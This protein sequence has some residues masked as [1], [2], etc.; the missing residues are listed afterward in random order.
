M[1][2]S[3]SREK[4]GRKKSGKG[5]SSGGNDY[6]TRDNRM[7][8][9]RSQVKCFNCGGYGH[10][11]AECRKPRKV[12]QQK[13]EVNLTWL[14]DSEPALLMVMCENNADELVTF[15]E[16]NSSIGV[17]ENEEN[18]WY[19]NNGAS[20]HM[21]DRREKFEKLDR[22]KK[23]EVK[24]GDGSVEQGIQVLRSDRGGE[25]CSNEFKNFCEDNGILR[26]Y[27][28]PYTPQQNGV[29][30]R[31]NR[32]VVAMARSLLKE[33]KVPLQFWGEAVRYAVHILN[34]LPTRSKSIVTPHEA[35]YGKKPSVEHLKIFGC[36]TYMK[37][38]AVQTTKLDDRSKLVSGC[39]FNEY[40]AW[41]W[42]SEH[43]V[44]EHQPGHSFLED[45]ELDTF[46]ET[47]PATPQSGATSDA[48][49]DSASHDESAPPRSYR[50]L[51]DMS[52][53]ANSNGQKIDSIEKNQTWTLTKLPT[54][55][56]PIDL[57]WVFK[58]KKDQNGEVT[59]HKARLVAKGYVQRQRVDYDE[60]FA[61]VTRL[62]TVR[63]LL[64]LAAKSNW[65]VHH[66]DVKSAFLNGFL[67]EEVYVSQPKGYVRKVTEINLSAIVKFKGEMSHEFDMSDL[68]N[69]SYYLGLEVMQGIVSRYMERPTELHLGAIKRICRYVQGAL[70]YGL[71]YAK[72]RGNYI[73]SGFS[74]SDLAGS[75]YDRKSTG[76]MVFYLDENLIT[77]VSQKQRCV[78]LSSCEAEF[79]AAT[80]AACHAI[81]LQRVL[82]HVIDIKQGPVTLY[83]DNR[84][85]VNLA[86]NP[87]FHGRSKHIDLRYHF[88]RDC[89]E[90]GLIVIKL[91]STGEQR[92]DIL[93]KALAAAKF[94]KMRNLLGVK[95]FTQV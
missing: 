14:S 73:L 93:T 78:A 18:I 89:V 15:T 7:V 13:G 22:T 54:C 77:W 82:S 20:N 88:I 28:A 58:I 38:P 63:L 91:V 17:K 66:L 21:T 45:D 59:N 71:I 85:A 60:V 2:S 79:M 65:E 37:V 61:P 11:A 69:L 53:P 23:G 81:W 30:E 51:S 3:S 64:A 16:G 25:F 95:K 24:F 12:R 48:K 6:R 47:T 42:E 19:L 4:N 72:G 83:I 8:R 75:T 56:K 90:K 80:T 1:T 44:T 35:W 29:V 27:T 55:Q 87:V 86:R 39:I 41:E 26:H 46:E 68:G 36:T 49:I 67:Q 52:I 94:E 92:A 34:K 32:T 9:D 57:K 74:D 10:F 33:K 50:L 62:E 5:G 43:K 40:Q 31:R 70:D 84:S 76:W